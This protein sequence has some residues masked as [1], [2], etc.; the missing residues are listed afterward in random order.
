MINVVSWRTRLE[1]VLSEGFTS[2]AD[3]RWFTGPAGLLQV[4]HDLAGEDIR[5]LTSDARFDELLADLD[6]RAVAFAGQPPSARAVALTR[7]A[8]GELASET[9]YDA[10]TRAFLPAA[11][12]QGGAVMAMARS[13]IDDLDAYVRGASPTTAKSVV[14]PIAASRHAHGEVVLLVLCDIGRPGLTLDVLDAPF[15]RVDAA[16]LAAIVHARRMVDRDMAARFSVTARRSGL[17]LDAIGG[18]SVGL[19]AAI[20][21]RRLR[22]PESAALD[23]R[24][25][26]TGA[27]DGDGALVSLVSPTRAGEYEAKLAAAAHGTFVYP[28]P[29]RSVVERSV[30]AIGA[31]V[32]LEAVRS[33]EEAESLIERHL[34]ATSAYQR[35]IE[36]PSRARRTLV[37]GALALVVCVAALVT[38]LRRGQDAD[39]KELQRAAAGSTF[40]DVVVHDGTRVGKFSVDRN[41]VTNEQY[42]ACMEA[43]RCPSPVSDGRPILDPVNARFP[44][45]G[46]T[47]GSGERFCE[48]ARGAGW[49][50]PTHD[51]YVEIAGQNL[52]GEYPMGDLD[53][54]DLDAARADL[55]NPN[56]VSVDSRSLGEGNLS[57]V[58]GNAVEWT[59]T[60]CLDGQCV[61]LDSVRRNPRA[62][63]RIVGLSA[64]FLSY[65]DPIADG[66]LVEPDHPDFLANA[67][68][69]HPD[70]GFRCSTTTSWET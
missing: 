5:S 33:V 32:R 56:L 36:S 4:C 30:D 16:F 2:D 21:L 24:W 51:Q 63:L 3:V 26:F 6:D 54:A 11:A 44:V 17:P 45:T 60:S 46:V 34:S 10:I 59:R 64:P 48:F 19:G 41:E 12:E 35:A 43:A 67:D 47:A 49:G 13:A 29:D 70:L 18:P 20:G 66:W 37:V 38:L 8:A 14:V 23:P 15:Q 55:P 53:G 68:G 39:G 28:A 57:W 50:L 31:D 69:F 42:L 61:D 7:I 1:Q 58:I 9:N 52:S 62:D 22:H 65:G 40:Y 27:I 25:V